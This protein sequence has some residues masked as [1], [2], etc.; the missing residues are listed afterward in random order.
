M[1]S[2]NWNELASKAEQQTNTQFAAQIAGLTSM[3]TTE[4]TTFIQEST[5]TNTNAI[6]VL[7]EVNN[8]ASANAEKATAISNIENGVG[9]LISIVS[10]IV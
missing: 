3:S 8:A 2:I 5:I 4:I 9:F 7:Q 1:S 6:K 10:K